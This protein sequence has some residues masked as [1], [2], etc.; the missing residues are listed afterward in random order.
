MVKNLGRFKST[1]AYGTGPI[2]VRSGAQDAAP[3]RPRDQ[4]GVPEGASGSLICR[5]AQH[6]QTGDW[7]AEDGNGD[8]LVVRTGAGGILEICHAPGNGNDPAVNNTG[9]LGMASPVPAD[10][11][12]FDSLSPHHNPVDKARSNG[13]LRFDT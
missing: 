6:G 10:R 13:T 3:R 8:P 11:R 4:L 1:D 7:T 9:R 12:G 2:P 5:I